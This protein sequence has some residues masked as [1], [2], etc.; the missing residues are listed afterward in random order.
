MKL[1]GMVELLEGRATGRTETVSQAEEGAQV[2]AR[3]QGAL[4]ELARRR[5]Q[6]QGEE[7]Q[8]RP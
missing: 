5:G 2:R 3:L 1:G 7:E 8:K 4:D 6:R